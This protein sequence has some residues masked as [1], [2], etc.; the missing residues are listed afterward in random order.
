MS[1]KSNDGKTVTSNGEKVYTQE[2][3]AKVLSKAKLYKTLY[4]EADKQVNLL[5]ERLKTCTDNNLMLANDILD[6]IITLENEHTTYRTEQAV[7]KERMSLVV[8]Q[9][10]MEKSQWKDTA[11]KLQHHLEGSKS[12]TANSLQDQQHAEDN[13]GVSSFVV[14]GLHG[15]RKL[16][17]AP[18]LDPAQL[19]R[20]VLYDIWV[21]C[22]N[23]KISI[24]DKTA[25]EARDRQKARAMIITMQTGQQKKETIQKFKR[26]LLHWG[27]EETSVEDYFPSQ[28]LPRAKQLRKHAADL[29]KAGRIH[30][31]R[32][33]NVQGAVVLQTCKEGEEY[34]S[35]D[36]SQID[37]GGLQHQVAD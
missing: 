30:G 13:K 4:E 31:Y 6:R 19:I 21:P 16:Y 2:D 1:G 24:A 25:N 27:I 17:N 32:V 5:N 37:L 36:D 26:Y 34:V 10:D 33:L 8:E 14:G 23:V 12:G 7:L 9:L 29:K 18:K 11:D 35:M 3:L 28:L 15:L 22:K 20:N